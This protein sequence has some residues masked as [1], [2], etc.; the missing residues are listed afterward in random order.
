MSKVPSGKTNPGA[1]ALEFVGSLIY[2][3]LV[4][5]T[6]SGT[7]AAGS[8]A[9]AITAVWLPLL[10]AVGVLSAVSLFILSFTNLIKNNP[11]ARAAIAPACAGGFS[12]VA[13]TAG[14][15]LMVVV[16]I[17]GFVIASAGAAYAKAM[18]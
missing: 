8:F 1:F 5:V 17:I 4:Y 7:A 6:S 12:F 10:Y 3:A 18:C 15:P 11:I 16:A 9:T 13:M 14:N 2:L